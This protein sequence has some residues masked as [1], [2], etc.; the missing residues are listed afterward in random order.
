M[1]FLLFVVAGALAAQ[2]LPQP[3]F[4]VEPPLITDCKDGAG[5]AT[6]LWGTG[7]LDPVT[8]FV[9]E[10]PMTGLEPSA[11]SART[12]QWV[13]DGME[14]SLR[15]AAG[16]TLATARAVVRCGAG[17]WWP[18][19]VGN[20]WHFRVDARYITGGHAVWRVARK[21]RIE[22]VEWSVLD[23]GPSGPMRLRTDS[24][25]RFYRLAADG[26]EELL[27]DPA[28]FVNGIWVVGGRTPQAVTLAGTFNEELSWRGPVIG[29]GV[30]FGRLGRGVGPTYYQTSVVAGSSGGLANGLTLLEAVVGGAR[31]VPNYPRVELSLETQSVNY[32]RKSARN[33]AIPCYFVACFGADPPNTYKP[34]ME[35][36]VK[37]GGG[38]LALLDSSGTPV[39]ETAADGWVRIPLYREP[40]TLL[41]AGKYSVTATVNGGTMTLPLEIQ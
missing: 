40:A 33:C 3:S 29:L 13:T 37:G 41:P 38:R 36:S 28:G 7:L 2:P 6:V 19:D 20:E 35:A 14:F 30:E 18:L 15:D 24:D 23:P 10:T 9:G 16:K 8:V 39:F 21:E 32:A 17:S 5:V 34:C 12:G 22:G 1:K 31:L 27:I 25:G 26:K 11:G 4:R